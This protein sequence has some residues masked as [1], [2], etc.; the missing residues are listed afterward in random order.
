[1]G[2]TTNGVLLDEENRRALLDSRVG[3]MGVSVAGATPATND[4]FRAG[5]PLGVVDRHLRHLRRE[6]EEDG[7]RL[8]EVHVAYLLLAGNV[9]EMEAAVD[10]AEAWGASDIVVSHLSLVLEESLESESLLTRPTE[11]PR[12]QE[13]LEAARSRARER[14]IRL[15]YRCPGGEETRGDCGEN[16]LRSCFVS[17]LGDVSPCVMA[18]V[19]VAQGGS[20]R[21]QGREES[22]ETLTFGNLVD[23]PLPEI[24][25][26]KAA[27]EFRSAFG[28]QLFG[29]R[30]GTEDLPDP[31]KSC[32]KLRES[33]R[34]PG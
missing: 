19:G 32:C 22:L 8:P 4:R 2:F 6:K 29:S 28:A 13:R 23:H 34:E 15:T 16:V 18:N 30:S 14:G 25:R 12:A 21:F 17:A 9:D 33:P 7:V 20:H 26:G 10:R 5:C 1:V 11:W 24:W 27:T 31:C 3:V